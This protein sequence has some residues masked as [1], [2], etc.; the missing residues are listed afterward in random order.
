VSRFFLGSQWLYGVS[1]SLGELSVVRRNDGSAPLIEGT[2]VG[3]DWDTALLR[4]LS[5][6]EVSA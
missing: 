4:V 3:L 1:T 6:D 2:A 5:V